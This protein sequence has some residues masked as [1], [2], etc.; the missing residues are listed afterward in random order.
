MAKKYTLHYGGE[1]FSIPGSQKDIV[2]TIASAEPGAVQIRVDDDK[3][4]TFATGPGI[5]A[6]VVE[7]TVRAPRAA[8]V[9]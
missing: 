3:M 9:F 5:A 6:V 2:E 7:Q 1:T 8:R 4:M